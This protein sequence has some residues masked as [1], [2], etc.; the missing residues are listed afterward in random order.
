MAGG[1]TTID[2]SVGLM[3]AGVVSVALLA[4]LTWAL[5]AWLG[6]LPRR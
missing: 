4:L 6:I 1:T 3:L 2:L 5:P